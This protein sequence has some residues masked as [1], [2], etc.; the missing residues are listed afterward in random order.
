[1]KRLY[2]FLAFFVLNVA[3][4]AQR[5]R[6]PAKPFM[7]VVGPAESAIQQ[8][9]CVAQLP[10]GRMLL[11]GNYG[12]A[13]SNGSG[14]DLVSLPNESPATAMATAAD[15]TVFVGG[16][17]QLGY[18][19][20]NALGHMHYVS[21]AEKL[22]ESQRITSQVWSILPV[23]Q[24]ILFLTS[25][26]LYVYSAGGFR[27]FSPGTEFYRIYKWGDRVLVMDLSK[28][29]LEYKDGHL[30]PAEDL[31]AITGQVAGLFPLV[32]GEILVI[33]RSGGV[34]LLA[35]GLSGGALVQAERKL[36]SLR[37]LLDKGKAYMGVALPRGGYA[38][39]TLDRGVI[40]VDEKGQPQW[41]LRKA[42]GLPDDVVIRLMVDRE[43]NLWATCNRGVA[44]IDEGSPFRMLDGRSGL[45]GTGLSAA[46]RKSPGKEGNETY[47]G[48]SRGVFYHNGAD[49]LVPF[50]SVP[51][52]DCQIF[53]LSSVGSE[54][55]FG[56]Q[57]GLKVLKGASAKLL[58]A[59]P[60]PNHILPLEKQP[61]VLFVSTD[62]GAFLVE[63]SGSRWS[64]RPVMGFNEN[65]LE[66]LEDPAGA[67]WCV[68]KYRG[69]FRVDWPDGFKAAPRVRHFSTD[70][71]LPNNDR[72]EAGLWKGRIYLSSTKGLYR[73]N[74]VTQCFECAEELNRVLPPEGD[75]GLL[76]EAP[77]GNL[78]CSR[79]GI[80]GILSLK[81]GHAAFDTSLLGKIRN[82]PSQ[83]V[84]TC[85]DASTWLFGA[86]EG[87]LVRDGSTVPSKDL[88]FTTVVWN[89]INTR[90]GAEIAP[91][92]RLKL[93]YK[94]NA[95][96]F[97]FGSYFY[98]NVADIRYRVML[99]GLDGEWSPWDSKLEREY[100]N[101][102]EGTY[103]FR[104][105]AENLFGIRSQSEALVLE[106]RPPWFRT[107][108]A[109]SVWVALVGLA[110][111]LIFRWRTVA[112]RKEKT[113]LEELVRLRTQ[114]LREAS[115]TDPLT[116]LRNR[117]YITEILV[118]DLKAFLNLKRHLLWTQDQRGG[119]SETLDQQVFGVFLMDIDHFKHVNDTHGHEA[120]DWVLKQ[121]AEILKQSVRADDAVMRIGGEEFLVVLKR[122]SED[123]LSAFAAKVKSLME[124]KEFKLPGGGILRRTCCIGYARFPFFAPDPDRV[125]FEQIMALA[126]LGLYYAKEHGR[127]MHV[128]ISA[129]PKMD[130]CQDPATLVGSLEQAVQ[131][132]FLEMAP[133][134]IP[135]E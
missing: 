119:T 9:W 19:A 15:G 70:D 84:L 62:K 29:L 82:I 123:Y 72:P 40:A 75:M 67:V 86:G 107:W 32:S 133:S 69:L 52:T 68:S 92:N 39:A 64:R 111:Y 57:E 122:T 50:K 36:D 129:G 78:W 25:E 79:D 102:W 65:I 61:G 74:D 20:L 11:G 28:G 5:L 37:K 125:S 6:L 117:R 45:A 27:T 22:P 124:T 96:R 43:A 60:W 135:A 4:P 10:S 76:R 55:Y 83:N 46:R 26:R 126:D 7:N 58:L 100:T 63:W 114:E 80:R 54:V 47:L 120:G 85:L 87:F 21:L 128:R 99:E 113:R 73:W 34:R 44:K 93:P 13:V 24:E 95:L 118:D 38:L 134:E 115:L 103:R 90:T 108:W 53:A 131:S 104:V 94:G 33:Y 12:V 8:N 116:G 127:N 3:L 106:I 132:G 91:A 77:D 59:M 121:F 66:A 35:P 48:T 110:A 17:C 56:D 16:F 31:K 97:K 71:G 18:L 41:H 89:V 23:G 98:E 101:L 14:W 42:D 51:G 30:K 105:E 81:S 2:L 112:L 88:P 1:M 109:I 49:P 130:E